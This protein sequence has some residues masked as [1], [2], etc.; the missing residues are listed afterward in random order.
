MDRLMPKDLFD[1]IL[2]GRE[3]SIDV[4]D[5]ASWMSIACLSEVSITKGGMPV[6]IPDFT[7]GQRIMRKKKD[8]IPV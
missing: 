8:V 3:T 2:K 5:A 6:E 7:N 1:A 4:Y